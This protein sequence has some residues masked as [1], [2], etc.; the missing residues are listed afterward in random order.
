MSQRSERSNV[1]LVLRGAI[2]V[3]LALIGTGAGAESKRA[4]AKAD[5]WIGKDASEL[6]LQLRV[7]DGRVQIREIEETGETA[8]TWSTWNQAWTETVMTG[9]EL[10][11]GPVLTQ[12]IYTQDVHHD[13]THRCDITFYADSEGVVRRWEYNGKSCGADIAK[14]KN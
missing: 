4:T 14:P 9:S 13:A 3:V 11:P 2:A 5:A 10:T 8:Y 12:T 6:L 1:P 7:D